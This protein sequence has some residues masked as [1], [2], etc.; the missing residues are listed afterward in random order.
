MEDIKIV[1]ASLLFIAL[2]NNIAAAISTKAIKQ[3]N[4][5]G[6]G[7]PKKPPKLT[8]IIINI[9]IDQNIVFLSKINFIL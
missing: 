1:I 5:W 8:I 2:M 3:T 4:L 7:K 6:R 9:P